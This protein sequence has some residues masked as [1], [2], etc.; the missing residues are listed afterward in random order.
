MKVSGQQR[1]SVKIDQLLR[2]FLVAILVSQKYHGDRR[3]TV[4]KVN[5]TN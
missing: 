4:F 2:V 3:L 5:S 1:I